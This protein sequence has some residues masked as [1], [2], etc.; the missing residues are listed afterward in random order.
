MGQVSYWDRGKHLVDGKLF[1]H[2]CVFLFNRRAHSSQW[3]YPNDNSMY[4]SCKEDVYIAN[5]LWCIF[6]FF[7]P[8]SNIVGD[9]KKNST[10][11]I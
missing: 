1:S 10:R 4:R 6:N 7:T 5:Y 2:V 3:Q 11:F 8:Y 9:I